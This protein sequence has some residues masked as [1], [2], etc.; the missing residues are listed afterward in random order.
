L[1]ELRLA[2]VI[3]RLQREGYPRLLTEGG[4]L[5]FARLLSEQIV[6]ELFVTSS[7]NVFG[8]FAND[9]RKS[10]VD[11]LDVGGVALDLWSVR[12]HGSHLFLRYALQR[13]PTSRRS[14]APGDP[15]RRP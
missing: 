2:D 9:Q 6:D 10:L 12:R 8:R 5:L 4:P 15:A 1:Q 13:P 11:G 7:P 14:L 3:A